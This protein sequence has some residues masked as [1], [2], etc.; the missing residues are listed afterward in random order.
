[1]YFSSEYLARGFSKKFMPGY[2]KLVIVGFVLTLVFFAAHIGSTRVG[3]TDGIF[4]AISLGL[5]N[6]NSKDFFNSILIGIPVT[7][8]L[9]LLIPR[10]HD[11]KKI[12]VYVDFNDESKILTLKTRRITKNK[13]E[14]SQIKYAELQIKNKKDFFDGMAMHSYEAIELQRNYGYQGYLLK[15]H[16]TWKK[17]DFQTILSKLNEIMDGKRR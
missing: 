8:F 9:V 16:F 10:I 2:L 12:I 15:D 13:V 14:D 6:M 1:M 11:E 4:S 5:K 17:Q 3:E 7:G